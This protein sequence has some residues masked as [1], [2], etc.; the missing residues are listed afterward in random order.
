MGGV[1]FGVTSA[2]DIPGLIG[3]HISIFNGIAV[4]KKL[5][6]N[7]AKFI[8]ARC[9]NLGIIPLHRIPVRDSL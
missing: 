7:F 4:F 1:I 2:W 3:M 5:A 9:D 8:L 6:R